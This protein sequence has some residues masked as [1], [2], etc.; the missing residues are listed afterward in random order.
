MQ[1]EY[2]KQFL[3][4]STAIN[5]YSESVEFLNHV[6]TTYINTGKC[7]AFR[8]RSYFDNEQLVLITKSVW[9]S[10]E[11]LAEFL[12]DS[13]AVADME[14]LVAYNIQHKIRLLDIIS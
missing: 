11:S 2:I 8:E 12:A 6:N 9:S 7:V 5:F 4:S 1:K 13:V 10:E 14:K 3:R